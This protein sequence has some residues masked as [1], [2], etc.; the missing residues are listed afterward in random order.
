[1]SDFNPAAVTPEELEKLARRADEAMAT[2][3][4]AMNGLEEVT[5]EGTSAGGKIR[6]AVESDGLLREI[7]LD[8]RLLRS[9]GSDELAE[10]VVAAVRAAQ[11]SARGQLEERLAAAQ[12]GARPSFD[13]RDVGRGLDAI[14][15]AFLSSLPPR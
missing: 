13:I 9:M 14:Q 2:L 12:G 5:G 8:P 4:Q 1:M 3:V 11:L 10:A 15:S 6:A 7:R